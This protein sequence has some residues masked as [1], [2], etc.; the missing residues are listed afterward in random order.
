MFWVLGEAG[1][2]LAQA[3]G[4]EQVAPQ[5]RDSPETSPLFG[6]RLTPVA[7]PFLLTQLWLLELLA[8]SGKGALGNSIPSQQKD[9]RFRQVAQGQGFWEGPGQAGTAK[10]TSPFSVLDCSQVL[11]LT[12]C[13]TL[14]KSLNS[15]VYFDGNPPKKHMVPQ[16]NQGEF[17]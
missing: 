10:R 15:S 6:V 5:W 9:H 16:R 3:L 13:V 1:C 2:R 14:G 8:R 12:L 4:M 11:S 17:N 7:W